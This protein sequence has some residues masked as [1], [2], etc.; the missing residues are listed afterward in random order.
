MKPNNKLLYVH[1]QS[2]HPPTLLNSIPTNINKRLSSIASNQD[3]FNETIKPYQEAIN[4]S[5]HDHQL[6]F[7]PKTENSK[8]RK[9]K[10]N[11]TW[12][13]PPWNANLKTNIGRKFLNAVNKCFPKNVEELSSN[14]GL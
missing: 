3:V 13:K 10:R 14:V 2:N 12:Y 9:R 1:K 7:Q 4:D 11:I 8:K 5:G 6:T